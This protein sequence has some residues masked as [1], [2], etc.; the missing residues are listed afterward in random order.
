M[1]SRVHPSSQ[2][3]VPSP[4]K[5]MFVGGNLGYNINLHFRIECDKEK[6]T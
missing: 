1:D 4:S 5:S 3:L 2:F 6:Q